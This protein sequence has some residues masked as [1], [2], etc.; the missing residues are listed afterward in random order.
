MGVFLRNIGKNIKEQ[1]SG[2]IIDRR[3][4]V[5]SNLKQKKT[6]TEIKNV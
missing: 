5:N 6:F 4:K 2:T 3:L 1:F